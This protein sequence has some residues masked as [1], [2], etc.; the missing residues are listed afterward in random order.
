VNRRKQHGRLE[1][2]QCRALEHAWIQAAQDGYPLNVKID[3]RPADNLKQEEHVALVNTTWNRL[4]VWSRRH[5]PNKTFHAV[6]VRESVPV[7]HFHIL[8]HVA[9]STNLTLLR[10]SLAR[11]FPE[12]GVAYVTRAHQV[13]T[14]TPSGKIKSAIGYITKERTPQAAWPKWLYRDG[15]AVLGKRYR[16]SAN[17]RAKPI[18]LAGDPEVTLR[19]DSKVTARL[20]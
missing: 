9:G 1:P 7:E 8:M 17:L 5:T 3:I 18:E 16:I 11:W 14:Y 12:A 15:R 4:G 10:Y 6:L 13:V 19:F 20:R 2:R